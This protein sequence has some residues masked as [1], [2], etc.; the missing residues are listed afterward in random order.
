MG[1]KRETGHKDSRNQEL[2]KFSSEQGGMAKT[3]KEGQGPHR[4]VELLMM[5]MMFRRS[6]LC[7]DLCSV[8]LLLL[9]GF[10]LGLF[11]HLQNGNIMFFRHMADF[12]LTARHHIQTDAAL[13]I[14]LDLTFIRG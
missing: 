2:E 14:G 8:C 11:A 10:L 12:H 6:I 1:G 7:L 3:S 9:I 13:E 4:A 5:M